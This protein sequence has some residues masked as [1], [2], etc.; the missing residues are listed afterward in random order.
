MSQREPSME[1]SGCALSMVYGICCM[2]VYCMLEP[3]VVQT[4]LLPLRLCQIVDLAVRNGCFKGP[5]V[6]LVTLA[7]LQPIVTQNMCFYGHN[8]DHA[9]VHS[10][11]VAKQLRMNCFDGLFVPTDEV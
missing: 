11:A 8:A 7:L 5:N 9:H 1:F 3:I 2:N 10:L 4:L 6:C